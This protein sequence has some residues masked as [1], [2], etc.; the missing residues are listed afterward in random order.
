MIIRNEINVTYHPFI[1]KFVS[2]IKTD[3]HG[4]LKLNAIT[5]ISTL[6][7]MSTCNYIERT[8]IEHKRY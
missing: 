6:H 7:P 8:Y 3:L 2:Q 5:R 4:L 1:M